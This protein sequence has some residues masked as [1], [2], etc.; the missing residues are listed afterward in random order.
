MGT[1]SNRSGDYS[2]DLSLESLPEL[3][4]LDSTSPRA[5]LPHRRAA[6]RKSALILRLLR[7]KARG[8]R[9][10]KPQPFY[11]IRAA[12]SH[13]GVPTTTISRIYKQLKCEGLLTSVWGSNT[14]IEPPKID[15]Q[16]Q[17]HGIV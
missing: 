7:Q 5:T 12:A 3:S 2:R 10:K 11:S 14:F 9:N 17:V 15:N 6:T 1:L 13:F 16:L 4:L 8:S